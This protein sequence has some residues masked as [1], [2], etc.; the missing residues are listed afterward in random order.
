MQ[1]NWFEIVAQMINF[2]ILLF[3]LHK[4]LYAPVIN[5][6]EKRQQRI[7]EQQ[8][9]ADRRMREAEE[10]AADY[11]E[12]LAILEREKQALLGE[13]KKEA[14]QKTEELMASFQA[15]AV[16][17]REAYLQEIDDEK[18]KFLRE[19]RQALGQKAV[20]IARRILAVFSKEELE[21][22]AFAAF[23]Q[24]IASLGAEVP[25]EANA[26]PERLILKSARELAEEQKA[27]LE[28][29]LQDVVGPFAGISYVVDGDLILGYEL[30]LET[31]TVHTNILKY[32]EETEKN[33][34][35]ALENKSF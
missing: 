14:Q 6:M 28:K 13:A 5:V 31:L 7:K 29:R 9:E 32:L 27:A 25:K 19:L 10:K 24:K 16:K 34:A 1:I 35:A 11:T 26:V 23:L 20:E 12:K 30:K 8:E 17:K 2:F 22:K 21:E 3:L 33:I 18:E 4:L 15:E